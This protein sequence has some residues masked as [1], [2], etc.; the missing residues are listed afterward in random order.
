[1]G[2][3]QLAPASAAG[4]AHGGAAS[5]G[6]GALPPDRLAAHLHA[7]DLAGLGHATRR[8]LGRDPRPVTG[9][10]RMWA[11]Q[12]HDGLPSLTRP[13]W[14]ALGPLGVGRPA[15]PEPALCEALLRGRSGEGEA[16]LAAAAA[17]LDT[18]KQVAASAHPPRGAS[19][20]AERQR[21][22][23]T[24]VKD[25]WRGCATV[26]G[27]LRPRVLAGDRDRA[28]RLLERGRAALDEVLERIAVLA[29]AVGSAAPASHHPE[30][31]VLSPAAA[32]V[33]PPVED[34]VVPTGPLPRSP[35]G[36]L[37]EAERRAEAFARAE[38][39]AVDDDPAPPPPRPPE[40]LSTRPPPNRV[41][42]PV[43][44]LVVVAGLALLVIFRV[45]NG[46]NPLAGG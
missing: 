1:V 15:G 45:L 42:A 2:E 46:P 9:Q 13:L 5:A 34:L 17:C 43:V 41:L 10:F 29:T 8:L 23:V 35:L 27:E 28:T 12:G 39:V 6:G 40:V 21:A 36:E 38:R 18:A 25:Y 19:A 4:T 7:L 33:A 26:Y 14:E 20:E 22:L 11:R 16:G 32:A 31:E 24:A 37:T 44:F 30:G 3:P